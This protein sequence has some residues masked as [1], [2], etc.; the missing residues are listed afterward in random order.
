MF[1]ILSIYLYNSII[2]VELLNLIDINRFN[3]RIYIKKKRGKG[4][5]IKKGKGT[6]NKNGYKMFIEISILDMKIYNN[7]GIKYV[8]I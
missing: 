5:K 8:M 3:F 7:C 6:K 4:T 2:R 1:S